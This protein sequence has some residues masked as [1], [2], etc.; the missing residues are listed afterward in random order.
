MTEL[1]RARQIC[2]SVA[3]QRARW[4]RHAGFGEYTADEVLDALMALYEAGGLEEGISRDEL[5]KANRAK[6][7]AEARAKRYK[8]QLDDANKN[9]VILTKALEEAETLEKERIQEQL[10]RSG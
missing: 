8:A 6:G 9:V 5:S 2:E 1:E 7:A 10:E 4:G 3:A